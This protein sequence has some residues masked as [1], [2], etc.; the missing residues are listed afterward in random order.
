M[1]VLVTAK[2]VTDPDMK[3]KVKADGSGIDLS[4]MNYKINPFDEIAIEEALLIKEKSGGEVV[5][6]EDKLGVT[7]TEIIKS[8]R[9]S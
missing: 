1:K 7:M 6:V 3:I 2:R 8:D 4:G 5:V 9:S